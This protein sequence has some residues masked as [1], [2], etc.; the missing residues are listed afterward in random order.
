MADMSIGAFRTP[1]VREM[2]PGEYREQ[3]RRVIASLVTGKNDTRAVPS[4]APA[5]GSY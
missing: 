5:V 4:L 3:R 2:T 1:V